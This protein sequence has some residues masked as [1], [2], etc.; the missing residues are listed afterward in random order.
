MLAPNDWASLVACV[1]DK[2]EPVGA[3]W[4]M[5][6][7]ATNLVG[8]K[9]L[10]YSSTFNLA[11]RF[12]PQD[13]EGGFEPA[14]QLPPGSDWMRFVLLDGHN[15]QCLESKTLPAAELVRRLDE[16]GDAMNA[17]IDS[18]AAPPSALRSH[19]AAARP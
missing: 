18:C 4:L 5:L 15:F 14:A 13:I 10:V 1:H 17:Q 6:I 11:I 8:R 16:M 19:S 7:A 9:L 12:V 2:K 3:D